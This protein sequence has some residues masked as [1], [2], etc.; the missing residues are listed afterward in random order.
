MKYIIF[1][2]FI[3]LSFAVKV[4]MFPT[5]MISSIKEIGSYSSIPGVEESRSFTAEKFVDMVFFGSVFAIIFTVLFSNRKKKFILNFYVPYNSNIKITLS[6]PG[7]VEG[8]IIV[9]DYFTTGSYK[10]KWD[11]TDDNKG[12]Y[13]YK[14]SGE[15][16][17]LSFEKDIKV[18]V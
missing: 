10:F 1:S 9:D 5:D 11:M 15:N 3:I 4:A 12:F 18:F 16:G 8:K 2:I 6:A 13:T 14:I 7:D 17:K